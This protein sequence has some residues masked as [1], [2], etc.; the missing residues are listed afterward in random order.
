MRTDITPTELTANAVTA[1]PAQTEVL[2]ANGA[3]I[4]A[5]GKLEET[6]IEI[7]P[8]EAGAVVQIVAGDNPPA[9]SAGQGNLKI[10]GVAE[11]AVVILGPTT[12]ARFVQA[13]ADSGDLFID[14]SKKIKVRAYHV[15][16]TA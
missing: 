3:R 2:A 8:L 15:P 10:E 12:S 9:L 11:D 1:Q 14:T 16:R 5:A 7:V 13:G 4:L 6:T